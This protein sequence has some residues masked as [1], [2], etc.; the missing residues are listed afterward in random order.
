MASQGASLQNYNNELVK[1]ALLPVPL[2][3]LYMVFACS[4]CE[5][6]L[7]LLC[8]AVHHSPVST[9]VHLSLH[10]IYSQRH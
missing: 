6:V 10:G 9:D 7:R 1:C 2:Q 5:P 3:L 4:R 8:A